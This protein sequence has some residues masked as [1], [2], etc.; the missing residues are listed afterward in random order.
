MTSVI[1]KIRFI[2]C[3]AAFLLACVT[4]EAQVGPG[5]PG[6]IAKFKTP[7][8]VGDSVIVEDKYGM[9]GVGTSLPTSKL[10]VAGMIESQSGGFK[11]PDGTVQLT[12]MKDPALSA[13]Q[14]ELE[15][16]YEDGEIGGEDSLSLPANKRLVIETLTLRATTG[17][18]GHFGICYLKTRVN[19]VE[20][21]HQIIPTIISSGPSQSTLLGFQTQV[22]L[23]ADGG[24][25]ESLYLQASRGGTA[26][27]GNLKLTIS[28]YL[29]DLPV[30][31]RE[32]NGA[33][34]LASMKTAK[35]GF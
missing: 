5:T 17:V 28:G 7:N 18:G 14:A 31:A 12:A 1:F 35:R 32:T 34:E 23:Y 30:A 8:S 2:V 20:I 21:R 29:V 4:A 11:F 24:G 19:G 9:V 25:A 27:S 16:D 13:F 33:N 22:R 15:V 10:T 3:A 6:A 26:I